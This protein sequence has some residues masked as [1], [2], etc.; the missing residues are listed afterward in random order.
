MLIS[1]S[2]CCFLGCFMSIS[3]VLS[4][5]HSHVVV[6]KNSLKN[7]FNFAPCFLQSFAKYRRSKKATADKNIPAL[8]ARLSNFNSEWV[9]LKGLSKKKFLSKFKGRENILVRIFSRTFIC[10]YRPWGTFK[11]MYII[12]G[13]TNRLY[14]RFEGPTNLWKIHSQKPVSCHYN[15]KCGYDTTI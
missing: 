2:L 14:Q 9:Y 1:G 15:F 11:E 6:V 8:F 13:P 12:Q 10:L 3:S 4:L 7:M 5:E